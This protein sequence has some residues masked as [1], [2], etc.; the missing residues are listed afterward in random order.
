MASRRL[1]GLEFLPVDH[2]LNR[3][4]SHAQQAGYLEGCVVIAC[5]IFFL[6]HD[7]LYFGTTAVKKDLTNDKNNLYDIV[8]LS[9][10][11]LSGDF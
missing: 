11:S 4:N 8:I 7:A 2:Q 6:G 1:P 3:S 5:G 9:K 10:I